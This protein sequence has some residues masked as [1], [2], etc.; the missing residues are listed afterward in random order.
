MRACA[1]VHV[2][3]NK[4]GFT[5]SGQH[6]TP[7]SGVCNTFNCF[8]GQNAAKMQSTS[9]LAIKY[10]KIV[11]IS[12]VHAFCSS[13]LAWALIFVLIHINEII[14]YTLECNYGEGRSNTLQSHLNVLARASEITG[15]ICKLTIIV[16][17]MIQVSSV[18]VSIPGVSWQ[19]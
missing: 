4:I 16:L 13:A 15:S 9:N 12:L 2:C 7:L 17:I 6:I 5:K 1:R 11:S 19:D 18:P 8:C 14:R 10:Q 3:V